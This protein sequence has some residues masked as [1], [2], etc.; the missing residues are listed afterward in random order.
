MNK[1]YVER[2][3]VEQY[4]LK[5]KELSIMFCSFSHSKTYLQWN[6]K[7]I[8]IYCQKLKSPKH[9]L[10]LFIVNSIQIVG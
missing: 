5:S 10:E 2:N 6:W 8:N 7:M 9:I 3:I 1:R 4:V